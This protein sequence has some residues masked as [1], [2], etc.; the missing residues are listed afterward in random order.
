MKKI[1]AVL[2]FITGLFADCKMDMVL[3]SSGA[4]N[5]VD[6][7]QKG[8]HR[9]ALIEVEIAITYTEQALDSCKDEVGSYKM[10]ELSTNLSSLIETKKK[11]EDNIVP[12][13]E[14]RILR[15]FKASQNTTQNTDT[16]RM[17]GAKKIKVSLESYQVGTLRYFMGETN[18]P[19]NTKIGIRLNDRAADFKIYIKEDGSFDSVG[20]SDRGRALKGK[21]KVEVL[22]YNSW[23]TKAIMEKLKKYY[24]YGLSSE[25]HAVIIKNYYF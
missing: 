4:E 23:Q 19:K 5:A 6:Y 3:A 25:G 18:L 12:T 16:Y 24:G 22:I 10:R 13:E 8:N 21:H 11:I 9:Y 17:D 7:A 20:F 1:I 2:F 15:E 14:E